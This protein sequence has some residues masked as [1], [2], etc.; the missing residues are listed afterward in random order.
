MEVNFLVITEK[1]GAVDFVDLYVI[2][3]W[4]L[5]F[6]CTDC[7]ILC[8][9][10]FLSFPWFVGA[11]LIPYTGKYLVWLTSENQPIKRPIETFDKLGV[12]NTEPGSFDNYAEWHCADFASCFPN[13]LVM[14]ILGGMPLFYLELALGQYYRSGCISIWRYIC[15]LFKGRLTF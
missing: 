4:M 10:M 12:R 13:Y 5:V 6:F 9:T 11:F 15:P 3:Y 1:P 7:I 2:L 14:L 8:F